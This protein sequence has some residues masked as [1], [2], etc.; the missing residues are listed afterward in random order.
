M[1]NPPEPTRVLI[2]PTPEQLL[3]VVGQL[4]PMPEPMRQRFRD[5]FQQEV[6]RDRKR[7]LLKQLRQSA[8]EVAFWMW[9]PARLPS[10]GPFDFVET[11]LV[12]WTDH[13]GRRHLG[14]SVATQRD[15]LPSGPHH[16]PL[17][18]LYPRVVKVMHRFGR[19]RAVCFCECGAWGEPA[20]LAWM[21]PCC[22]P[23]HDRQADESFL[24]M[25]LAVADPPV[26]GV[27]VASTG[28][29]ALATAKRLEVYDS[30]TARRTHHWEGGR[31]DDL[32]LAFHPNGE[33]LWEADAARSVVHSL[34][35]ATHWN[36]SAMALGFAWKQPALASFWP[37]DRLEWVSLEGHAARA[38]PM[39][40][41][42]DL[43]FLAVSP[44]ERLLAGVSPGAFWLWSL[45][46]PQLLQRIER[47]NAYEPCGLAW[48]P[49]GR[50]LAIGL[51]HGVELHVQRRS[52]E[53]F[54]PLDQLRGF[55]FHPTGHSVAVW[56]ADTL[57]LYSVGGGAEHAEWSLGHGH[58]A[59]SSDGRFVVQATA[60]EWR[61]W[62]G[63]AFW[64]V[65]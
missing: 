2:D 21:G 61:L 36:L 22:G 63:Q 48:S 34:R 28:R 35:L 26:R 10:R 1:S 45:Q 58:L 24:P 51:P 18:L 47:P 30:C 3:A 53:I 13:L 57:R 5:D 32:V 42:V 27:A 14:V 11:R 64:E 46:P 43:R 20:D 12:W 54:L 49:T 37:P 15:R 33:H 25:R 62:P 31:L 38:L 55:V 4:L 65:K 19:A 9:Q 40:G 50:H 29:V 23:C 44:D 59:F 16:P 17:S 60:D 39:P 41:R 8:E 56:N 7:P 6:L 52:T